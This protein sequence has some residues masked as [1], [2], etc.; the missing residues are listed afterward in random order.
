MNRVILL[1]LSLLVGACEA[2]SSVHETILA[3]SDAWSLDPQIREDSLRQ[4]V[5]DDFRYVDPLVDGSGRDHF[6]DYIVAT[7][8]CSEEGEMFVGMTLTSPDAAARFEWTLYLADGEVREGENV[9]FFAPDG[10][11]QEMVSEF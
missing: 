5:A 4:A 11:I 7:L 6:A 1:S 3:Y 8:D 10:R 9:A 2:E